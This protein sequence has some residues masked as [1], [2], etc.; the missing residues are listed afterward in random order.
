MSVAHANPSAP[1]RAVNELITEFVEA[2]GISEDTAAH[3]LR[4]HLIEERTYA[5]AA[6]NDGRALVRSSALPL[7]VSRGLLEFP[8]W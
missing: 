2:V 4:P 3:N 8:G 7:P 5:M 6:A 1:P